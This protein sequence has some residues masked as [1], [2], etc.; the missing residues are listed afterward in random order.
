MDLSS[1]AFREVYAQAKK[2]MPDGAKGAVLNGRPMITYLPDGSFYY[3]RESRVGESGVQR[4]F[5]RVDPVSGK[6]SPLF[7]EKAVQSAAAAFG[8]KGE[9]FP[10]EK[11]S[12]EET[13][14]GLRFVFSGGD[15]R[16]IWKEETLT[17]QPAPD[18]TMAVSPD[19]KWRVRVKEGNLWLC[20]E[21]G[22]LLRPLTTDGEPLYPYAVP[23]ENTDRVRRTIQGDPLP[24][25]VVWSPDGRTLLT[26]RI[27]L[28]GLGTLS[29][30]DA[31]DRDGKAHRPR[32]YTYRCSF[33]E[34][35]A[36]PLAELVLMDLV[37]GAVT[38]V[39]VPPTPTD[40]SPLIDYSCRAAFSPDGHFF[41]YTWCNRGY[42][43]ARLYEVNSQTGESRVLVEENTDVFLNIATYG[44]LDG[45][46]T[47]GAS[48]LVTADGK[49]TVWQ[50]EREDKAHLFLYENESGACLSCL[51]PGEILVGKLVEYNEENG[52]LYFMASG[53]PDTSDPYYR[54]LCRVNLFDPKGVTVLTPEDGEHTITMGKDSFVDT[55]SRA[56]KPPVT[57]LRRKDGTLVRQL[58]TADITRLLQLGYRIPQRITV[59]AADGETDLYGLLFLPETA[60]SGQKVPVAEY[61][62]G[63]QQK[64]NVMK[65]FEWEAT[66]GREMQGA[67]QEMCALGFAGLVL[68]GRGTPGRGIAFHGK[69]HHR[70]HDCAGLYDHVAA[71]PQLKEQ[72]PVLDLDRVGIYGHSGGGMAAAR[73][74]LQYPQVYK[75]AVSSGGNHDQRFYQSQWIERY[76][77]L[78]DP[79]NYG[80]NDPCALVSN[81]QG[82][83][84]LAH[85]A[86][87]DNVSMQQTLR[88]VDALIRADKDF[89]YLTFPRDF[90]NVPSNPYF[91]RKRLEFL[92]QALL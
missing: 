8:L 29:V 91:M 89:T 43:Q 4:R 47:Y 62:Y 86:L 41:R 70:I 58:E 17:R 35:K 53:M 21:D 82:K 6:E 57:V 15:S 88:L 79:E 38:P 32:T 18:P 12:V 68:D 63:G 73:A 10:F 45:F 40:Y 9:E 66:G 24:P 34:D 69:C 76:N 52:D 77:G 50:S 44:E 80:E 22:V 84:F 1:Q 23:A 14:S 87:D 65:A 26:H 3:A 61:I 56:D 74:I 25:T 42:S 51:T 27:D 19:G 13:E 60:E 49:Y 2:L 85:G 30:I 71:L 64:Y 28:R 33:T 48:N 20:E 67:L 81:L 78:Y 36:V 90:H 59:K 11:V 75:A 72:F 54:R 7:D 5:V 39:Q 16:Y 55:W 46:G 92:A 37:T 31:C 83:L